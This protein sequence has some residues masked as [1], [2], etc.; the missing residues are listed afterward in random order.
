MEVVPFAPCPPEQSKQARVPFAFP[1]YFPAAQATHAVPLRVPLVTLWRG[2]PSGHAE[3]VA[4]ADGEVLEEAEEV[5]VGRAER[6]E[7]EEAVAVAVAVAVAEMVL[8]ACRRRPR[9]A[10]LLC[11]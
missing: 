5:G 7:V 8:V 10:A 4:V 11:A 9:D 1:S 2:N 3:A 6:L